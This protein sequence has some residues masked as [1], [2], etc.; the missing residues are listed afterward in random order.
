MGDSHSRSTSSL[1]SELLCQETEPHLDEE[2]L[3]EDTLINLSDYTV[4]N[5]EEEEECIKLLLDR[6]INV[7]FQTH[8]CS[9]IV[10][11]NWIKCARLNAIAWILKT[12]SS[13]GF[14]FQTGYL[15]M[16][17]FDRFLSRR[18]IDSD[19]WWAMQL[20]SMACLSLAAKMEEY[21][22]PSPS[23][24][25][26]EEYNFD[27]K[28]IQRMELLVLNTLEWRMSSVTP[29]AFIHYFIRTLG[30]HHSPPPR[31][32]VSR[33]VHLILA[34]MRDVNLMDH[35]PSVIAGA[36]TL[37]ALNRKLT[38]QAFENTVNAFSPS[39]I[40]DMSSCYNQMQELDMKKV[41]I[42]PKFKISSHLSPIRSREIDVFE[43]S[44]VSSAIRTQKKK[45]YIP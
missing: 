44:L 45:V 41:T 35:R 2:D 39:E 36:A 37:V 15:A 24:F 43:N 25:Q 27:S 12:R 21:R 11:D 13:L 4:S 16:T 18:A 28:V 5:S 33:T 8:N 29:F 32:V 1:S 19:K 31:N 23:E 42:E 3:D 30:N 20:L 7:G 40:E 34:I 26:L 14:R 17:Y 10:I 22:V 38:K 6:E 9:H